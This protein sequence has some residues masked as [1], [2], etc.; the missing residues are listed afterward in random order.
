MR[1]KGDIAFGS[2]SAASTELDTGLHLAF[3]LSRAQALEGEGMV[4][5]VGADRMPG[6]VDAPDDGGISACHFTDEEIGRLHAFRGE[7]I[8][9]GVGVGRDRAIVEGD[10]D[11]MVFERQRSRILHGTDAGEV[12]RVDGQNAAGAK[13]IGIARAWLC[14]GR[15]NASNKTKYNYQHATHQAPRPRA[16]C[17]QRE[18]PDI[19]VRDINGGLRVVNAFQADS[20]GFFAGAVNRRHIYCELPPAFSGTTCTTRKPRRLSSRKKAGSIRAVCALV[21]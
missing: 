20:S 18:A 15:A 12:G 4:L 2:P 11:L 13:R 3:G 14:G 1:K 19:I 8:E 7:G 5:A 16:D 21:S 6:I 17:L 9:D 10:D